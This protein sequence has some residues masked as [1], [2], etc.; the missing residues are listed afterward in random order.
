MGVIHGVLVERDGEDPKAFGF[1]T[2]EEAL[3]FAC[4]QDKAKCTV[5]DFNMLPEPPTY[6]INLG[7]QVEFPDETI[8]NNPY[9]AKIKV[10]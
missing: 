9:K 3:Q 7:C 5:K 1:S 10:E 6:Q 4:D 2:A 8:D